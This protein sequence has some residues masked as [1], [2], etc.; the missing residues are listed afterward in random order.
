MYAGRN[1]R[2]KLQIF[3]CLTLYCC[4]ACS[5]T[6][7]RNGDLQMAQIEDDALLSKKCTAG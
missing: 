6:R 4:D 1:A 3:P 5:I 2:L 7:T